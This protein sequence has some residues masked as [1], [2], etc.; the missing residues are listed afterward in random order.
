MAEEK[1][2]VLLMECYR[3]EKVCSLVFPDMCMSDRLT[4]TPQYA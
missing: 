4:C 3:N 2:S 1:C